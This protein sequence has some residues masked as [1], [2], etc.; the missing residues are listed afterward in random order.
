MTHQADPPDDNQGTNDERGA[1]EDSHPRSRTV[2]IL[3]IRSFRWAGALCSI[4]F[5]IAAFASYRSAEEGLSDSP[6]APFPMV[7]AVLIWIFARASSTPTSRQEIGFVLTGG[8]WAFLSA[9]SSWLAPLKN[10]YPDTL[11]LLTAA[12]YAAL[13]LTLVTDLLLCRHSESAASR[14]AHP[15]SWRPGR[16]TGQAAGCF[17]GATALL[18][19]PVLILSQIS[20]SIGVST[21]TDTPPRPAPE[22]PSSIVGEAAWSRALGEHVFNILEGS[23]GPVLI[24]NEG[25]IGLNGIDGTTL[26]SYRKRLDDRFDARAVASPDGAHVTVSLPTLRG[27]DRAVIIE[28][29]TGT[30]IA[31]VPISSARDPL[32]MSDRVALI[33]IRA[34]SLTTGD[35]LWEV[36][37]DQ[38]GDYIGPAG[39]QSLIIDTT[40]RSTAY[41]DFEKE[42]LESCSMS[43][44]DD[45]DP[46]SVRLLTG[47][48]TRPSEGVRTVDGWVIRYS[49]GSQEVSAPGNEQG[50]A[51]SEPWPVVDGEE[52]E[53]INIDTVT[54]SVEG[55][56]PA[57]TDVVPLGTF[58][59]PATQDSSSLIPLRQSGTYEDWST[60]PHY[61]SIPVSAVFDPS[62]RSL[63]QVAVDDSQDD[64]DCERNRSCWPTPDTGVPRSSASVTERTMSLTLT[65][66]DG[67]EPIVVDI[68][69]AISSGGPRMSSPTA[70]RAPGGVVLWSTLESGASQREGDINTPESMHTVLYALR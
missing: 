5:A 9:L 52:M 67:T 2:R 33:G 35:L 34:F 39:H 47:V 7:V 51:A 22:T 54:T 60:F 17:L 57:G 14:P 4:G 44:I 25:I 19:V 41:S 40:C 46:T 66:T 24:T 30:V 27:P 18:T 50:R 48:V 56:A 32:Q 61:A 55:S 26:W 1:A 29:A 68:D 38:V 58:A 23:V 12:L 65:R 42:L 6:P 64:D 59:G 3:L 15:S 16:P 13:T 70:T 10:G 28:S 43:L 21:T 69:H 11:P 63:T 36:G 53:A 49:E 62:T 45:T 31:E 37:E 20:P 8:A